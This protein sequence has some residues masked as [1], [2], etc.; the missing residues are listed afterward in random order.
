MFSVE[1]IQCVPESQTG[2][3]IGGK[4]AGTSGLRGGAQIPAALSHCNIPNPPPWDKASRKAL[5]KPARPDVFS[6]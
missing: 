1:Q 3:G 6:F 2:L 4:L 5:A